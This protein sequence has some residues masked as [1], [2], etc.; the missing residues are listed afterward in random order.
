MTK[1]KLIKSAFLHQWW[2]KLYCHMSTITPWTLLLRNGLYTLRASKHLQTTLADSYLCFQTARKRSFALR[3]PTDQPLLA[4]CC[5]VL[6][7]WKLPFSFVS[8]NT[9]FSVPVFCSMST[10]LKSCLLAKAIYTKF[11]IA[12]LELQWLHV[13]TQDNEYKSPKALTHSPTF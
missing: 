13:Q 9:A 12:V 1:V 4:S 6:C 10:T 8:W 2:L 11:L 5:R 3:H 7:G